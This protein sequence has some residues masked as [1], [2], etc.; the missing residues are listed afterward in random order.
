[1]RLRRDESPDPFCSRQRGKP[2][3]GRRVP[4][5]P[6]EDESTN[7]KKPRTLTDLSQVP[8]SVLRE[9]LAARGDSER[10]ASY[11]NS[12]GAEEE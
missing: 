1:M 2:K 10:R 5:P 3:P 9:A 7:P 6:K 11:A 12:I 8:L 4:E